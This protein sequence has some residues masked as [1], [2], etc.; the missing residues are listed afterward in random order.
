MTG[1][2]ARESTGRVGN[3]ERPRPVG[4]PSPRAWWSSALLSGPLDAA[5]AT[6]HARL[7]ALCWNL[8]ADTG[9]AA[10][11]RE[12]CAGVL[13]QWEM[14]ARAPD[15]EL[16]VSEL[17]T[18]ALRHGRRVR[19][20]AGAGLHGAEA[21]DPIQMSLLRRGSEL[22]CAVRD[23]SDRMPERREPGL[24]FESGRGLHLVS[25]FCSGWGVLPTLPSGKHVWAR[26]G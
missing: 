5:A 9:A 16:V 18:N 1:Q 19:T 23:R 3:G 21:D 24:R 10:V 25:C 22:V 6:C 7:E 14:A 13:G 12:V 15:V 4:A 2:P 8:E 11:A 26:F 17:V 20:T